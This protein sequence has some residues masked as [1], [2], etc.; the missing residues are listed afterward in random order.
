MLFTKLFK[1]NLPIFVLIVA[2][3]SSCVSNKKIIYLQNQEGN[4]PIADN[5]LITYEI[6]DYRL[7]FNDIIEVSVQTTEDLIISAFS[8]NSANQQRMMMGGNMMQQ[9]GDIYYMTGYSID[10]DGF[11]DLP[12]VG[13]VKVDQLTLQ[14]A[15]DLIQEEIKKYLTSDFFLRVKLGGIRFSSFGEFNRPGKYTILQDRMT[16]FEAI[17]ASGDLNILAKRDELILIRQ[18]PDGTKIHRI[19]LMDRNI[20]SSPYYFI[21]PNDQLY[22]EPLKVR[23]LGTNGNATQTIS[24]LISGLTAVAL[25]L[26]L[27]NNN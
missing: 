26:S 10:K 2:L 22:A 4:P 5:Q 1:R 14:E 20:I 18:Y 23:Q 19:N 9:G 24:L 8:G 12:L 13:M 17:S 11:V 16:I 27:T 25:I 3:G 6:P 7:Q 21:Q 15:K